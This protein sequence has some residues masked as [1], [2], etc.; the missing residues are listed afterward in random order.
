MRSKH[1][2]R[3]VWLTYD[4]GTEKLTRVTTQAII[5]GKRYITRGVAYN[6]PIPAAHSA[7]ATDT[8][9]IPGSVQIIL[10]YNAGKTY[11]YSR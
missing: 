1:Y 6:W 11:N 9:L 2:H 8:I 10:Q 5:P 4:M 3:H 7:V